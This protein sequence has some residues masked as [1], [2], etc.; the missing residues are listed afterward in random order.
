MVKQSK[1]GSA[2]VSFAQERLWFLDQINPGDV[3]ANIS[4]G[5]RIKGALNRDLLQR[6]LQA[7]IR[8]HESLRTTFAINQLH[9]VKDSKP[10]QLVA[11]NSWVG[12]QFIDL[13]LEPEVEIKAR[14]L[15]RSPAETPFDLTLGPL[16]RATLLRLNEREHVLLLSLHRIVCDDRSLE[17]LTDELWAAYG[18]LVKEEPWAIAP[19]QFQYEDY[20][21]RQRQLIEEETFQPSLDFW[22]AKVQGAP[23]VIELPTDRPRPPVQTWHGQTVL[24][25][26]DNNLLEKLRSIAASQNATLAT[27]LLAALRIVLA[28]YSRQQD[29]VIGTVVANRDSSETKEV[30]GPLSNLLSLRSSVSG[31]LTFLEL[32]RREQNIS[33]EAHEN[34]FVPFEKL[35]DELTLERSLGHTPVFQVTFSLK[36]VA[37]DGAEVAGLQLEPFEFDEDIVGYDLMVDAYESPNNLVCRFRYSTDLFDRTTIERL[38][39]HFKNL[40]VGIVANPTE[41]VS[42][43]PLLTES[44]QRQVLF[45]WNNTERTFD[46][47]RNVIEL[48]ER[49]AASTPSAVA[50]S[51]ENQ[52]LTYAELNARA[53]QLARQLRTLGVRPETVVGI[54]LER[55]LEMIIGLLGILKAGGAYMPLDP[56]LPKE[57]LAFMLEDARVPAVITV[58]ALSRELPAH[59]AKVIALDVDQ[60]DISAQS[61]Q[62]PNTEVNDDNLAYV[63][64][65]SGSTGRPKGTM[66]THRG[67]CN[68]LQWMQAEYNLTE[69]DR[70]LQKTPYSFDVSVWEFFWPLITG[71]RLVVARPGGHQDPGYLVDII[72]KEQIT[73]L[74]FVP[75]MMQAFVEEKSVEQCESV[76][77]VISSGEALSYE[78]QER[79]FARLKCKL[80]NLYG[81]TEASIDVTA[82]QCEPG[83][84]SRTV[85]IG[86]PIANTQIYILDESLQPVPIGVPGE[87]HIGGKGLGRGYLNRPDLTADK[88]IPDPYSEGQRLYKTGDLARYRADGNIEYIGRLDDQVKIRGFRI[89]LGEIE[90]VLREHSSVRD[91]VVVAR[92]GKLVAYVVATEEH[93]SDRAKLW[94]ELRNLIK[95]KLPEYMLPAIFVEL[96][97][98][99]LTSSGKVDRRKLPTPDQARPDLQQAYVAPRDRV[100][101]QLA[102]LWAHLL[103]LKSVGV[104]DNFFELGG[105]SLLAA[106]L[107]AQIENRFGKHIPLATLFQSPTI[108]Q[109]A[110]V[111]RDSR[112][113]SWSSL[114][115]IQ[116]EG[117]KQRL[118]CIH[119]AGANVLIYRPLSRHLGNE[120]PVYALQA[121]GLDGSQPLKT[122]EEMAAHYIEEMRLFQRE[123]P[124]HLL[125]ASFGG[126]VIYEMAYQLSRQNQKV[127]LV[128]MLNTNCPVYTLAKRIASHVVHL[129]EHGPRYYGSAVIKGLTR[130]INRYVP[131]PTSGPSGNGMARELEI[132]QVLE[133]D[134][135]R[136]EA[137]VRTV[138]A[139][140][141]AEEIYD[142]AG[143]VYPGKVTLFRA[144][145]TKHDFHDNRLGWRNLAQGGV[146][147]YDV[148]GTHT[149]MREEP[150][151]SVLVEKLKP[152]LEKAQLTDD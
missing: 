151:V 49:Q 70:V 12:I 80:H 140:L 85:P 48:F 27:V 51:F 42:A 62:N 68:R 120:Q 30:I 53:N 64:Y 99:P 74:H 56:D 14:D 115:A 1:I 67:L 79:F 50:V 17:I 7:L 114:V 101:E 35:L 104:H 150:N 6:S 147:V 100:E 146:E 10:V 88:F 97:A 28:R 98:L 92:E 60:E 129:R 72:Q 5:I 36:E 122:V 65:T 128:G 15:A 8:R 144:I 131:V 106:R 16:L 108:E 109:L 84:S 132:R 21:L 119:A 93:S 152:C 54:C 121:Q 73:T 47:P 75:S 66:N 112:E 37:T 141:R 102:T 34:R 69:A 135:D 137:L 105:H 11:T 125:G 110:T 143:R 3:S 45:E 133:A 52:H 40:L 55:S 83:A 86:Q 77:Q 58:A 94:S 89:E 13:S 87:L 57:R 118:F 82:W 139:I 26:L 124:Y 25:E 148:P 4:R 81:P 116:P 39:R 134:R 117:S 71:A 44:E 18:A 9:A 22:R 43:L 59:Q 19:L 123:G 149:S 61:A 91:V 107:F 138:T 24:L 2:P 142:P 136:D 23:S 33:V 29:L 113:R 95:S 32:L 127:G 90:T 96:D 78:L 76:R 63:I 20:A 46:Q 41:K 145:D 38:T 31:D 103:K 130:R 126:L 111:L